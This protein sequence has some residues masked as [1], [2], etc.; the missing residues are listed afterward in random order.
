MPSF[1]HIKLILHLFHI[2]PISSDIY[3]QKD[4]AQKPPKCYLK[5]VKPVPDSLLGLWVRGQ[6]L[7]Q[8]LLDVEGDE[9][10]A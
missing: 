5:Y 7:A 1:V 9:L 8:E 6:S 3:K 2:S 10:C 4:L